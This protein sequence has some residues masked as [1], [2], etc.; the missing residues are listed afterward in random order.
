MTNSANNEPILLDQEGYDKFLAEIESLK[1]QLTKI[2]MERGTACSDAVG[3]S[4]HDNFAHDEAVRKERFVT[5]QLKEKYEQLKRIKIVTK[6]EAAINEGL[7]EI[8]DVVTL[9]M[10]AQTGKVKEH[11]I[12]IVATFGVSTEG[13]IREVSIDSPLGNAIY[14]KKAG[15]KASYSVNGKSFTINIKSVSRED[16]QKKESGRTR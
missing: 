3:D 7:V 15:D 11:T 16:E 1:E 10:I 6:S 14:H 8:G 12:K 9:D 2:D 13:S 4:W 5:N